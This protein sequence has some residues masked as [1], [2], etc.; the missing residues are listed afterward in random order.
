MRKENG[1]PYFGILHHEENVDLLPANLELSAMEMMLVTTMSRETVM[2][3]YLNKVKDDYEYILI[4]CMPS[5]GKSLCLQ[6]AFRSNEQ[7]VTMDEG[8]R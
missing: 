6:N 7:V 1:N 2:R 8:K 3:T 4:D 5:L